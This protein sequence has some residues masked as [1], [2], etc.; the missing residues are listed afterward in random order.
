[1]VRPTNFCTNY[2]TLNDNKFMNE[3]KDKDSNLKAQTEFDSFTSNLQKN[4]VAVD[5]FNQPFPEASDA[6]FPNNWFSTHKNKYFPEGLL[7]IYPMKSSLRRLERNPEIIEKFKKNYKN[8]V[9]LTYLENENEYLESTGCLIFDNLNKRVY[10]SLSERATKKAL[11]LF[12]ENFNKFS[13]E[14]FELITFSSFDLNGNSI[15]HTNVLLSILENHVVICDE[16]IKDDNERKNVLEKL[17][18]NRSLVKLSFG[19]LK[20]FGCNVLMV[21]NNQNENILIISQTALDGLSEE[22]RKVLSENY[23]ICVNKINTIEF[24]GGGSA[25][26]MVGEIF[27]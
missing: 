18:L 6:I 12:I 15:Y 16:T 3:S 23:I 14:K 21:K 4:D 19:E 1:M 25:R 7:I 22:N 8:F 20:N 17:T 9:D 26:C 10:C 27:E 5:I 24:I 11:Y 2:E 13:T